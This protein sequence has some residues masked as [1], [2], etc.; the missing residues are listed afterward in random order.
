MNPSFRVNHQAIR[1]SLIH[2][3]LQKQDQKKNN[4]KKS[5]TT[6][7]TSKDET[8]CST[9]TLTSYIDLIR[10][11]RVRIVQVVIASMRNGPHCLQQ[12]PKH[13]PPGH[14]LDLETVE[15]PP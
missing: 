3:L 15:Q 7:P 6:P 2:P 8:M 12:H 10:P 5:I 14:L 1:R 13:Q 9:G 4:K 11:C